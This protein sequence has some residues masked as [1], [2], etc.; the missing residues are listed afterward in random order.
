MPAQSQRVDHQADDFG[1]RL[2]AA[3]TEQF[4]PRN[5]RHARIEH[6]GRI[7]VHDGAG[8]TEPPRAVG[9]Q[10]GRVDARG[11][12]RHVGADSEHA[13]AALVH[14]AERLQFE[15]AAGADQQRVEVFDQRRGDVLV[16]PDDEQVQH[17]PAQLF[18]RP[19]IRR[20]HL[21]DSVRKAPGVLVH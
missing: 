16:A 21:I 1:I 13:A 6:A 11:L 8:V 5:E 9:T 10:T 20:Q 19:R 15:I 2:D 3:R 14:H 7:R 17:A 18:E 12:R 4:R